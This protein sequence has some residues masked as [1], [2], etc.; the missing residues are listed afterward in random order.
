M[1]REYNFIYSKLVDGED[2]VVG[3]VAYS[4]YKSDKIAFIEAYKNSHNGQDPTEDDFRRF[5][6]TICTNGHINRYQM[7]AVNILHSFLNETLGETAEQMETDSR[8]RHNEMLRSIVE[9][10]TG[11]II[12]KQVPKI[13]EQQ[14]KPIMPKGFW[15]G[16]GQS[17]LGALLFMIAVCGIIFVATLSQKQYTFTIGGSGNATINEKIVSDTIPQENYPN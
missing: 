13:M 15:Y 8:K 1:G 11:D 9:R 10:I 17:V 3:T 2:D 4:I 14:L 16:V 12:N 6:E 5:H 7:Q